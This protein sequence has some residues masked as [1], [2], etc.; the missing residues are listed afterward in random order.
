VNAADAFMVDMVGVASAAMEFAQIF[1]SEDGG[2]RGR[3]GCCRDE[4]A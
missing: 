2:C 3:I 1:S 4:K